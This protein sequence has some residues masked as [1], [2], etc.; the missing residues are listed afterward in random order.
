MQAISLPIKGLSGGK[1]VFDFIIGQEFFSDFGNTQIK[2]ADFGVEITIQRHASY[3]QAVCHSKGYVVVECDRCLDDLKIPIDVTSNLTVRFA[4]S[5]VESEEDDVIV[6][7]DSISELDLSQEVYDYICLSM[8]LQK[9]HP[10][11]KCNPDVMKYMT[12][13]ES[14]KGEE[15][16]S[17]SPFGNLKELIENKNN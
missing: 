5:S 14:G 3:L 9:V 10:K 1:H 16:S 15:D 4:A 7:E 8:P 13:K 11:G 17:Y 2:D 6:V 12:A